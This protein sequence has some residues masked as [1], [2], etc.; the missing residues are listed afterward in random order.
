MFKSSRRRAASNPPPNNTN[1]N[2]AAAVAA[3]QAFLRDRASNASLS[4]AAAA[5][6]LRSHTSSPVPPSSIQTKRMQRKGSNASNASSA[7]ATP[8]MRRQG[9]S[10]SM[11]QRSFRSPSPGRSGNMSP[12]PAN[13]PPVPAIPQNLPTPTKH[14]RSASVDPQ[15]TRVSSPPP[16]KQGGRGVSVDRGG[17]ALVD[18][19]P[20]IPPLQN[21][22][23][24]E[25]GDSQRS[26]N[27]SRPMSPALRSASPT[28]HTSHSGWFT[29]P[30]TSD[31]SPR[32]DS[33]PAPKSTSATLP[34][35]EASGI[36][37]SIHDAANKPVAKKK[38]KVAPG[39]EGS[40]LA[41]G[42]MNVKPS[43]TAINGGVSSPA[44][45]KSPSPINTNVSTTNSRSPS[46][47]PVTGRSS[48][49]LETR[50]VRVSKK[51]STV[52]ESPEAEEQEERVAAANTG[53]KINATS[54]GS[55]GA[56][57]PVSLA[58][59]VGFQSASN[60]EQTR[61]VSQPMQASARTH[62]RHQSLSPTRSAHFAAV[63]IDFQN[64]FK[65]QPPPRSVSP[66]KSALKHSPS[67]S[68]RG[69]SP[70]G[71][72]AA[73]LNKGGVSD[74]SDAGSIDG[75]TPTKKKKKSVRV[76]F[77]ES[78]SI[79]GEDASPVSSTPAKT[80]L[81]SS[82]RKAKS[83]QDEDDDLEEIMKPRP[84]LPLFGS[85]RRERRKDDNDAEKVTE[86][87]PSLSNSVSTVQDP[88][89]ASSDHN[90]GGIFAKDLNTRSSTERAK[91]MQA[92]APAVAA[93]GTSGYD[94]D[95]ESDLEDS[96]IRESVNNFIKRDTKHESA[97][98]GDAKT[99]EFPVATGGSS[100]KEAADKLRNR[101]T[102]DVPK[103]SFQPP[104][105][106]I[107]DEKNE[108]SF[109]MPGS[110][111][112]QEDDE[113][114]QSSPES[115]RDVSKAADAADV[116]QE[117]HE[118]PVPSIEADTDHDANP[119]PIHPQQTLDMFL[120]SVE[121]EPSDGDNDSIY[122]DAAE[123]L[124][125]MEGGFASLDA[126]VESPAVSPRSP[127]RGSVS[128]PD[129]P[130][131][132][133]PNAGNEDWGQTKAYW[134]SLSDQRKKQIEQ[135]AITN[136]PTSE[137][138]LDPP[139]PIL[140]APKK[141]KKAVVT[142]E[143]QPDVRP[144]ATAPA[145]SQPPAQPAVPKKSAM[146][147]SMREERPQTPPQD[148]TRMRTSMRTSM[149]GGT[150]LDASRYSD[151]NMENRE[152][153]GALQKKNIP[154][155]AAPKAPAAIKAPAK[156]L[157]AQVVPPQPQRQSAA[158][159]LTRT[160][161]N[162]SDNSD[163]SFRRHRRRASSSAASDGRY[164]MKRSMRNA[165]PPRGPARPSSPQGPPR[166]SRL[167][168]RSLSPNGSLFGRRKPMFNDQGSTGGFSKSTMRDNKPPVSHARFSG[169][170]KPAKAKPVKSASTPL[171]KSRF[172]DSSDEEDSRPTYRSRFADSDD[173][174]DSPASPIPSGLRPVRGIPR[175]AGDEDA[176]STDLSDE[177]ASDREARAP[178]ATNKPP[179][180]P[181]SKDIEAASSAPLTN[182][183]GKITPAGIAL[184]KGSLRDSKWAN[185]D[186]PR[187]E[188]K[189]FFGLGGGKKR[190]SSV[191]P[192]LN[193]VD[194]RPTSPSSPGGGKLQRRSTPSR[195]PS[196]S[197]PL[198]PPIPD[199]DRTL[200]GTGGRPT[201]SDGAPG[202]SV[203]RPAL[204]KRQSTGAAP[205]GSAGPYTIRDPKTGRDVVIGKAGK[206][207]KFPLLRK[208]FGLT[209]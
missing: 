130:L 149:R 71:L 190:S 88:M 32:P 63:A 128:P 164:S 114:L 134:S 200:R 107:E 119:T 76:S 83:A 131:A 141:K 106:G 91:N 100:S 34:A 18:R 148:G 30:I 184:A 177:E 142:T 5:A 38:K 8:T 73:S 20:R 116:A 92:D 147:K 186:S 49:E 93:M 65:H 96:E 3:S 179:P 205:G 178:V 46:E 121:E 127:L 101:E 44:R 29:T 72:Q 54:N 122:S 163:S 53:K 120:E 6:A 41:G 165:S 56:T 174:D 60:Q 183:Q 112:E 204:G 68:V 104:T 133:R 80:G 193:T 69:N 77:D 61:S 167:S 57:R 85:I 86:T 22:P 52:L 98:D 74:G 143:T 62:E 7:I 28:S 58:I 140:K 9:S 79:A 99:Q 156:R 132:S 154:L 129:S 123:D 206:K 24:I 191:A 40:H 66:A 145:M 48:D 31:Q 51:P 157:P 115:T 36:E 173:E 75:F 27:F 138:F 84:A 45:A 39:V 43:G 35:S 67:S 118:T 209:D 95:S 199:D 13:A 102:N 23:E 137:R 10:G 146:R 162:D 2:A 175:R 19:Y 78:P 208:V 151:A 25:R 81:E 109:E 197:W 89:E 172:N 125:E 103:I 166:S 192:S 59:P 152:P 50:P 11:S 64:G 189:P 159:A 33:R 113:I 90:V 94:S 110:W 155:A 180:V 153:K 82:R 15:P 150:G 168:I 124:S 195:T 207:K 139:A 16:R 87:V 4:S 182:G 188:K 70:S 47:S 55:A 12:L 1:V 185:T 203:E 105:P 108:L 21:V 181:S 17:N 117:P 201:T 196:E 111:S 158:P 171:F 126:I 37:Q 160:S 97:N 144:K 169:M 135:E 202:R 187:K 136:S 161:S 170:S 26:I 198:P 42:S 194:G 176:E 14:K